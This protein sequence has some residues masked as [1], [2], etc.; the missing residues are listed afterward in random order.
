[1]T[2]DLHVVPQD[3]VHA[4]LEGTIPDKLWLMLNGEKLYILNTTSVLLASV[5]HKK[6]L[7][8]QHLLLRMV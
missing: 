7:I 4:F 3:I 5:A 1:M 8:N 2:E 6:R